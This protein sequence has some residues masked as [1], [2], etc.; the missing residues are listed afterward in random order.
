[1][2]VSFIT[3]LLAGALG[4]AAAHAQEPPLVGVVAPFSGQASILGRQIGAGALAAASDLDVAITTMDDRCEAEGGKAAALRLAELKASFA[5]GF[6][7]TES[8]EAALPILKEAG[9]VA[10][11]VGVRANSLTDTHDKTGWPVIRLAP[12]ADSEAHA[13]A[14]LL[15]PRWRE[16]LFAI[17]D[18]GTIGG[19]ELAEAFRAGAEEIALKPVF[20]DT[21][22]PDLD[23]QTGLAGRLRRAGA[24]HV[25]V[26][27]ARQDVATISRDAA[28][29][30]LDLT[31]AG[32]ENLGND[33]SEEPLADGTLMVALPDWEAAARPATIA[34]LRRRELRP[35][36]YVLPAYAAMEIAKAVRD[37]RSGA[38]SAYAGF[39]GATFET[40]IG[41][42]GFD[43]KGDLLTNPYELFV[44]RGDGFAPLENGQ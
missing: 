33:A 38:S 1:M 20:V 13:V 6:L 30:G 22:R 24:T 43:A 36:G 26:G 15:P 8:L 32:G 2:R 28:K 37:G 11:T 41:V 29:L 10:I 12:R 9:I 18:D 25:F 34:E 17:V 21:Y 19:R 31:L 7:C 3:A 14:Q 27:G 42:V 35:E 40:V 16:A 23:N 44:W 39:I 5:V 4:A